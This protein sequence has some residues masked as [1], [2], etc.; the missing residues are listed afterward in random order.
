MVSS[1]SSCVSPLPVVN[2]R[3]TAA[4][5]SADGAFQLEGGLIG[6]SCGRVRTSP[7]EAIPLGPLGLRGLT[8]VILEGGKS[9]ASTRRLGRI[10]CRPPWR[11]PHQPLG[12][13][14]DPRVFCTANHSTGKPADIFAHVFPTKP[15]FNLRSRFSSE[16]QATQAQRKTNS[17]P[18]FAPQPH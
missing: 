15:C 10:S 13:P 14:S 7:R 9:N 8:H 1:E 6:R 16:R 17:A 4:T 3:D 5:R 11:R 12:D 2:G 18:Q